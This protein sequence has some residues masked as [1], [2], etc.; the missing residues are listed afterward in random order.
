MIA[1]SFQTLRQHLRRTRPGNLRQTARD[2]T[3]ARRLFNTFER[4][5]E[6]AEIHGIHFYVQ[7]NVV[8]LYG[9]VRHELDREL[10]ISL[11]REI[12]GVQGVVAHLQLVDTRFQPG[13]E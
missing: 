6:L 12:P 9:T 7:N 13:N 3:L 10:L 2:L 4:D 1:R 5:L 11:V 8:T